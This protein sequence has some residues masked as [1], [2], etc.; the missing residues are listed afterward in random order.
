MN[1]APMA[2]ASGEPNINPRA[3]IP[4]TKLWKL[5]FYHT[6]NKDS[7]TTEVTKNLAWSI[8]LLAKRIL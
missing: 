6:Q 1:F 4:K 2:M 5:I 8:Y 3:S 7:H